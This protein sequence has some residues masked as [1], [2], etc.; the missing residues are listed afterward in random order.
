MGNDKRDRFGDDS[1]INDEEVAE[2]SAGDVVFNDAE[3]IANR[4]MADMLDA[5]E[6]VFSKTG[7]SYMIACENG[8]TARLIIES[9]E[10]VTPETNAIM[11]I[12]DAVFNRTLEPAD[13]RALVDIANRHLMY[14]RDAGQMMETH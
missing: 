11:L 13:N 10:S 6:E 2:M 1:N 5:T 9:K 4:H 7:Y 12:A 8:I 3:I 14:K